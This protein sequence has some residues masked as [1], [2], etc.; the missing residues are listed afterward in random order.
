[1]IDENH[2]LENLK[3]F[4]FPRLSGTYL[5]RKSFMLAK[6]KIESLN[7]IPTI[8]KFS[9]SIFYSR[10]YPKLALILLFWLHLILFL[11][12]QII[13]TYVN[14]FVVLLMLVILIIITRNPEQIKIGK[15]LYS[16]NI[17]VKIPLKSRSKKKNSEKKNVIN[18]YNKDIFLFSHLDSKGQLFSIKFR[19]LFYYLWIFSFTIGLFINSINSYLLLNIILLFQIIGILVLSINGLATICILLNKTN[20]ISK[21]AIDNASGISIVMELLHYYSNPNNR[22]KNITLWF[23][24]T[25]AEETGTMGVRNFYK[26]IK[27]FDRK[28][29]FTIN[30][31][32]IAKKAILYNHGLINNSYSKSIN[33]ILENEDLNLVKAKKIYIGT[34]SDGLFLLNKKFQGLGNGDKTSYGYLHSI[35]DNIDKIDPLVL[36]KLCQFYTILFEE[37]ASSME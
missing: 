32:S 7:L 35:D 18:D 19:I 10:V 31:D 2:I 30:F 13:F 12:I 24:F 9:F 4:S 28:K 23:V 5:E 36:K 34:Y 3:E 25:G 1:M 33:F 17:F 15:K 21:G 11:N 8:Q 22:L 27:D 26:N 14:I 20:N 16:Q 6:R 37:I 29:T